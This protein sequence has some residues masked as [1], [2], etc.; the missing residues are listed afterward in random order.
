MPEL[1]EVETVVRGLRAEVVGRRFVSVELLR[2][3]RFR[4]DGQALVAGLLHRQAVAARRL[5]KVFFLDL[6]DDLTLT[7]HLRMT[8]QFRVQDPLIERA[9]HTH[10]ILGLDDGRELRWRD[11]RRFG[12]LHLGATADSSALPEVVKL[13]A[14][15]LAMPREAFLE[16]LRGSRRAIKALLLAQDIVAGV[17]NIYADE[18]LH[19]AGVNPRQASDTLSPARARKVHEAMLGILEAAIAASGSSVSQYVDVSGEAGSFQQSHRV[20]GRAGQRCAKCASAIVRE[21]IASR[22]TYYCPH[23]QRLR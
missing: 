2:G 18:I 10:L 14:D 21:V 19:R 7:G 5:G 16:A 8:G 15:A 4:P 6:D 13:G 1:P 17:G 11:A 9:P 22:G 3:D 23:C 20:Y 12:W